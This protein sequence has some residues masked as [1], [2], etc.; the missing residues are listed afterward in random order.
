V[1]VFSQYSVLILAVWIAA[2]ALGRAKPPLMPPRIVQNETPS[3]GFATQRR[4][5]PK[6]VRLGFSGGLITGAPSL[7][8]PFNASEAFAGGRFFSRLWLGGRWYLIPA[9]GYYR[10]FSGLSLSNQATN[11]L[12]ISAS[13]QYALLKLGPFGL[14]AGLNQR[15][16]WRFTADSGGARGLWN[17]RLGPAVSLNTR[18]SGSTS[19]VITSE[20]T[21]PLYRPHPTEWM[22]QAGLLIAF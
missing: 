1:K 11:L 12:E 7:D 13:L 6:I 18:L 21:V 22:N 5:K 15:I 14:L 19:L 9:V 17:Y 20:F 3:A 16:T 10:Q 8:A 2:P 4:Q